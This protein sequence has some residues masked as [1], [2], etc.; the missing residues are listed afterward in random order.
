MTWSVE[1]KLLCKGIYSVCTHLST[2]VKPSS[3]VKLAALHGLFYCLTSLHTV[4]CNDLLSREKDI[5]VKV[6]PA[7]KGKAKP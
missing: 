4:W 3:D 5:H 2:D 6:V 7:D 1:L